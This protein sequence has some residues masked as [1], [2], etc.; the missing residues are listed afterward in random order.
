MFVWVFLVLFGCLVFFG[1]CVS[2]LVCL[3]VCFFLIY[4]WKENKERAN[5]DIGKQG[6]AETKDSLVREKYLNT[7]FC[8]KESDQILR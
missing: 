6:W 3:F 7:F 1:G 2:V 4:T 5:E 8:K